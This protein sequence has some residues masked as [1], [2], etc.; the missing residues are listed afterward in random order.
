MGKPTK[1]S[2]L[3]ILWPCV[4]L[5]LGGPTIATSATADTPYSISTGFEFTRGDYGTDEKTS[6]FLFP[7]TFT[8]S[9]TD[10]IDIA[11]RVAYLYQSNSATVAMGGGRFP[12]RGPNSG[13]GTAPGNG[14]A[15]GQG[16]N[17]NGSGAG[18][19]GNGSG[20]GG[21][22]NGSGM[23]GND[24]GSG[25]GGP[26]GE[27][28]GGGDHPAG[29][30]SQSGFGDIELT[31]YYTLLPEAERTPFL[32]AQLYVKL[33]TADDKKGLG[34]GAN[35]YGGGL[36]AGKAFDRWL[37]FAEVQYITPGS[38]TYYEPIDYWNWVTSGTYAV[39]DQLFIGL[40]LTGSTAP[41]D[42]AEDALDLQLNMHYWLSPSSQI[43]AYVAGGLSDGSA[44]Y[45]AGVYGSISF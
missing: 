13:N 30:D 4:A 20:M 23:G 16:G 26:P 2:S 25:T 14:A 36:S 3:S 5:L 10:E 22:G 38:S 45:G 40:D 34:T 43:G 18:G 19:N 27:H 33:A 32:R 37:L 17:G 21:N 44:D 1:F 35:D 42:G 8:A 28:P 7:V 11:M 29:T 41:F 9:F 39:N 24:N 31:A 12:M 6:S 15:G